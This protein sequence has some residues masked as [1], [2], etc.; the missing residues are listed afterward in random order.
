[1]PPVLALREA[2]RAITSAREPKSSVAPE[3]TLRSVLTVHGLAVGAHTSAAVLTMAALAG[4]G[5]RAAAVASSKATAVGGMGR[6]SRVRPSTLE[7]VRTRDERMG[8]QRQGC[9]SHGR[10]LRYSTRA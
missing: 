8:R 2:P 3:A 1:M 9:G 4:R 5:T 7:R 6:A 10:R